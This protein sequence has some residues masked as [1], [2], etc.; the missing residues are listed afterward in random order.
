MPSSASSTAHSMSD[1][2]ASRPLPTS[3]QAS[4]PDD[5][6]TK[7]MP[8]W[9][10]VVIL[11]WVTGLSYIRVFIAGASTTGQVAAS[12][13]AVRWSLAMPAAVR[14]ITSALAGAITNT[15]AHLASSMWVIPTCM[16]SSVAVWLA[17]ES[18]NIAMRTD[19]W[20]S[21]WK[22]SGDTNCA[23]AAVIST[24]T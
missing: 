24:R 16:P 23:A 17:P 19:W 20:V 14:A 10:Q 22:V 15:S 3:S 4:R 9:R 8:S 18:S 11:R 1:N 13:V 21:D 12:R 7:L 2:S 6:S 5:G